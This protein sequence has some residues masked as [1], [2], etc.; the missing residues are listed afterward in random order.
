MEQDVLDANAT[1]PAFILA[2]VMARALKAAETVTGSGR[3]I[4]AG[5]KIAD[6]VALTTSAMPADE[7]IA[8]GF[9]DLI[10]CMWG[11]VDLRLDVGAGAA[12]DTRILRAFVDVGFLTRRKSSFAFGGAT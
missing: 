5:G 10:I 6:R 7:L 3:H 1:D 12:S 9:S 11:G 2:P 4:M 8:G